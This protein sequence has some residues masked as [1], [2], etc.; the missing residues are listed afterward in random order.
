MCLE[1]K[2]TIMPGSGSS[3][4]CISNGIEYWNY[5][6]SLV[7][8]LLFAVWMGQIQSKLIYIIVTF[9]QGSLYISYK[10]VI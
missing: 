2:R 3:H 5:C 6:E 1:K 7:V 10:S 9:G 4:F 8:Y